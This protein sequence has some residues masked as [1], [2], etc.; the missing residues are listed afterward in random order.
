MIEAIKEYFFQNW[1]LL[2]ILGAF[3][4]VLLIT[5]FSNKKTT[6]RYLTL[7]ASVFL[8]SIVVFAE[9]YLQ[10]VVENKTAR[11]ILMTIRYSATPF[12]LALV[13]MVLVKRQKY[14]VFIPAA[15][16][17]NIN[18][19][20]IFTGIVFS[21][22]FNETLNELVLVRGPLGYMPFILSGLYMIFLI[23]LLILRSNKRL[24]EIA[25]IVFLSIA[26]ASGVVF[27]F[28]FGSK[29]AQ[30]FCT[31]IAASL[32]IYYV[33]TILELTKK[34]ALTGV[35]NR[36]AYY[37]ETRRDYKD[38]TAIISLDMNGLKAINDTYG[39]SA[40]D[41]ALITLALCFTKAT[42]TRQSV[43]RMGGDEFVIV[44]RKTSKEE[45]IALVERIEDNVMETKYTCSIG[46][47]YHEAG[48][49]KLEDLL[50][51]SDKEMYADKNNF[52]RNKRSN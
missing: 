37:I 8:L 22:R 52:Y 11:L 10:P 4:V 12:V 45:V 26:L 44:C 18:I 15:L 49:I 39:H 25:P 20:S 19:I 40:G 23:I 35:L 17:L 30:I 24:V 21:L 14:F 36:E 31:I 13:I 7:L 50:R 5:S 43:Y 42:R 28:I 41:E 29:F 27:P 46:F 6:I 51:E 2:L 47:S 33:F 16:M 1:I 32:F 3:I 48:T 34:D 38:I 9:F